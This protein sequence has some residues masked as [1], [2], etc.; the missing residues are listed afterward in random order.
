MV[1]LKTDG[2]LLDGVYAQ[3]G[4]QEPVGPRDPR[5]RVPQVLPVGVL[6]L[7]GRY[8]ADGSFDAGQIHP[9][10]GR[11]PFARVFETRGF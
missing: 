1:L 11:I 10:L 3:P 4:E 7:G 8:L 2:Q 9:V 6:P 5:G